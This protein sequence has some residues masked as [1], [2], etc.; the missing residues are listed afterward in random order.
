MTLLQH[1]LD[2]NMSNRMEV[3]MSG[4]P[5]LIH[6]PQVVIPRL[7]QRTE[8]FLGGIWGSV[9][10]G[11]TVMAS[12][13]YRFIWSAD[14]MT[15]VYS[16]KGKFYAQNS[17]GFINE[18]RTAPFVEG[19]RRAS[20]MAT[21]AEAEM[22]L[23]MGVVA[24]SSTAGFVLV[25]GSEVAEFVVENREN[26]ATWQRQLKAVLEAR[27]F[28]KT[29]APTI[30][31][32]LFNTVLHQVCKDTRAKLPDA[33]TADTV[34]FGVGVILGS[35]GKKIAKGKFSM[36]ALIFV[37]VEQL[38]IRFVLNVAPTALKLTTHDYETMAREIVRRANEAGVN[39][40]TLDANKILDEA[41]QHPKEI[42]R[43]Y[44]LLKEAFES[45]RA[46]DNRQFTAASNIMKTKHD[47]AKN[48][49]SNIR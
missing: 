37:I 30:Y 40:S 20:F 11:Q 22:K 12:D 8:L 49:L 29:H 6:N 4:D 1:K 28:L 19:A 14:S 36:F 24:G 5:V 41:R 44:D 21:V 33:I 16:L 15:V 7:N 3:A 27:N 39:I 47:T 18:V 13:G 25:I 38:A 34:A 32:K 45:V 2:L 48:S 35:V 17:T 10:A 23:L 46:A 9:K 42:K 43:A 26:F 31:D